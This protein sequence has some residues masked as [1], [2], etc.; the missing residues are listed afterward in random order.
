MTQAPVEQTMGSAF[1]PPMNT[2]FNVFLD[3]RVGKLLDLI[4]V[5]SGDAI[6]L[7]GFAVV[8]S[9][10]HA[11][12]RVL[13]SNGELAKRLLGRHNLPFSQVDVL[14]VELEGSHTLRGLCETLLQAELNIHYAYPL[15]VRPRGVPAVVIHTDDRV[16][17]AQLLRRKL[18][19]LLGEN[20][21]GDNS[22][23]SRP[24]APNDPNA[25]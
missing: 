21:L 24:G 8:E 5:F 16:F 18:Y 1:E 7:A 13:T 4:E 6:T 20:D 15:L 23:R 22:S 14:V 25:N 17:A 3:N 2:Q 12:V 10:D 11:V 19:T 9:V